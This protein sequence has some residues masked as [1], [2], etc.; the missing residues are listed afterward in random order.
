[1]HGPALPC[2][3]PTPLE[4]DR[5]RRHASGRYPG[6][7]VSECGV[8]CIAV[9]GNPGVL[10]P[11]VATLCTL[12]PERA[13]V[14]TRSVFNVSGNGS[15]ACVKLRMDSHLARGVEGMNITASPVDPD[16]LM[17]IFGRLHRSLPQPHVKV[18]SRRHEG[19]KRPVAGGLSGRVPPL[20]CQAAAPSAWRRSPASSRRTPRCWSSAMAGF[21]IAG[22][23]SS[24]WATLRPRQSWSR[25]RRSATK[26]PRPLRPQSTRGDHCQDPRAAPGRRVCAAC[27]DVVR[28]HPSG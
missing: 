25:P 14:S 8:I 27:G 9:P 5:Q 6:P 24:K 3:E 22:H 18:V 17:R 26:R 11:G 10:Q 2:V 23:R 20:S 4:A 28:H 1:M 21:P 13:S 12:A 19:S 16:G 15:I 7:C